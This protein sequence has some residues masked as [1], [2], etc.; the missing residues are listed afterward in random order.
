MFTWVLEWVL[1]NRAP[2]LSS[3]D[4]GPALCRGIARLLFTNVSAGQGER[5]SWE[6]KP[7]WQNLDS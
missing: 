5:V 3:G 2:T 1:M 4:M 7:V 6:T